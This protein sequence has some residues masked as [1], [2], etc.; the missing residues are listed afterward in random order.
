MRAH[1]YTTYT[2]LPP[3]LSDDPP[4]PASAAAAQRNGD[5][6]L[7]AEKFKTRFIFIWIAFSFFFS[8]LNRI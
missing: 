6:S 3:L 1:T 7:V 4:P 2:A 5:P 8:V